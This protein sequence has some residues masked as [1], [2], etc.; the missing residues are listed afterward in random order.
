MDSQ[1]STRDAT[2]LEPWIILL[3]ELPNLTLQLWQLDLSQTQASVRNEED[4]LSI[5]MF[6]DRNAAN[7]F[8]SKHSQQ[9]WKLQ[10]FRGT[11]LVQLLSTC[12]QD[13]LRYI[14][15]NPSATEARQ[16]FVIREILK[17]A[18]GKLKEDRKT[19]AFL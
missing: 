12:F 19:N 7:D 18:L 11:E 1:T 14:A 8:A 16:V 17:S 2:E 15:L 10:Q 13:G 6:S 9:P 3:G 4:R 5:A